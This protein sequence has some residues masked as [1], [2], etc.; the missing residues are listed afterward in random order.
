MAHAEVKSARGQRQK[1]P[2]CISSRAGQLSS[3]PLLCDLHPER[4]AILSIFFL[5]LQIG[6]QK[7]RWH[8]QLIRLL[9]EEGLVQPRRHRCARNR[10]TCLCA[11]SLGSA[12]LVDRNRRPRRFSDDAPDAH[13]SF[14]LL[15]HLH[16]HTVCVNFHPPFLSTQSAFK[17]FIIFAPTRLPCERASLPTNQTTDRHTK[18]LANSSHCMTPTHQ[19]SHHI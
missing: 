14:E 7:R 13:R 1:R 17:T 15:P 3:P 8:R 11:G 10:S 18:H 4:R 16:R 12:E 2:H 6:A 5:P 19:H 9:L